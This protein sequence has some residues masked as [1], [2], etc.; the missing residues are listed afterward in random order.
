MQNGKG[1]RNR[2]SDFKKYRNNYDL[3]FSKNK[4][5]KRKNKKEKINEVL[6]AI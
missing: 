3:I 1:S 6:C 5:T 2:V 4:N